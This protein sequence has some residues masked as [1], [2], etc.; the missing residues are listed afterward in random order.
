[1]NSLVQ[2]IQNL[3]LTEE[4]EGYSLGRGVK[5]HLI[6][7][8][9]IKTWSPLTTPPVDNL[10]WYEKYK[11]GKGFTGWS[12]LPVYSPLKEMIGFILR[13]MTS[14][15]FHVHLF[16]EAEWNPVFL[17]SINYAE[18]IWNG[19][20]VYLCEGLYDKSALD[21]AIP[22]K[23]IALAT[24]RAYI[25]KAHV[26]FLKR[27][28]KGRIKMCYDNDQAGQDAT[29]GGKDKTGNWFPGAVT[30]FGKVGLPVDVMRY[31]GKDPG[32]TWDTYGPEG[33]KHFFL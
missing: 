30:K 11:G 5:E 9:G 15:A 2:H 33:M 18:K 17:G 13:A 21:W 16:K 27:F 22:E 12:V 32:V 20:D 10:E 23:D 25:S 8:L 1:M 14:K 3:T 26:D 24:S 19:A 6:T 4:V 29:H 7:E 28:C 31:S